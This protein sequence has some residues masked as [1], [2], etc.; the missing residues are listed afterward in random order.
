MNRLWIRPAARRSGL[1]RAL[2]E[3]SMETARDLGFRR[4][5][6]DVVPGRTNAIALYR[7]LGFVETAPAHV[8]P[9]AMV[10][11]ARVL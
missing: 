3:A 2:C 1:G 11:L 6:L 8:Y 9:F 5:A 7:S 10:F 4:M